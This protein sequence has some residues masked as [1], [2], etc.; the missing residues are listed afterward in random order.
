MSKWHIRPACWDV[1]LDGSSKGQTRREAGAQNH[2]S[3]EREV[4]GLPN[5]RVDALA[6]RLNTTTR[7]AE[8]VEGATGPRQRPTVSSKNEDQRTGIA[9]GEVHPGLPG[10]GNRELDLLAVM[11]IEYL[12]LLRGA[13]RDRLVRLSQETGLVERSVAALGARGRW[14]RARAAENLGHFGGPEA[15]GPIVRLFGNRDETLRAV[16]ARA[17]ARIGTPEAAEALA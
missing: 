13:E 8:H 1:I 14:R 16:A 11:M 10:L 17:P 6:A 5:G 7:T 4:A 2:G 15:V 12:S 3:P 9:T